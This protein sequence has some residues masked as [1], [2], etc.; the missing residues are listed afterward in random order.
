MAGG[1]HFPFPADLFRKF[2]RENDGEGHSDDGAADILM[3]S[4]GH[5]HARMAVPAEHWLA[6]D[7]GSCHSL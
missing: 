6:Y 5:N 1:G 3:P 7:A 4:T 2:V